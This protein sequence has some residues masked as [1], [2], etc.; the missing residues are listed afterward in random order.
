MTPL[1]SLAATIIHDLELD[2]A[3]RRLFDGVDADVRNEIRREWRAIVLKRL[4]PHAPAIVQDKPEP[5]IN[6][7]SEASARNG[8]W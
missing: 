1:E 2:A 3:D 8:G 5:L 4:V 6:G 7:M